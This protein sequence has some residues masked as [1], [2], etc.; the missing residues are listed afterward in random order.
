MGN[1]LLC[2]DWGS[3][4]E[5]KMAAI[6]GGHVFFPV[7]PLKRW[8]LLPFYLGWSVG[9][10]DPQNAIEVMLCWLGGLGLK[11][12]GSCAFLLSW[13][14]GLPQKEVQ[15]PQWRETWKERGP[16]I[17]QLFHRFS[18][19]A[20]SHMSDAILDS[21]AQLPADTMWHWDKPSWARAS[22][23]LQNQKQIS[24][25]YFKPLCF[26]DDLLPSNS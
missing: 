14:P 22:S 4:H 16:V 10:F 21:L 24:G 25:C 17:P 20:K 18:R 1:W 9:C 8:S 5:I 12:P 13:S 26:E 2:G 11:R 7:S 3:Y 15:L 19:C 23:K 6:K